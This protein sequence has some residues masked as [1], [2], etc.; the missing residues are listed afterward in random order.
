MIEKT[1]KHG[2]Q[3][4]MIISNYIQQVTDFSWGGNRKT[5]NRQKERK[6]KP[7]TNSIKEP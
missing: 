3:A 4:L 7:S 1:N 5:S 6:L 2:I